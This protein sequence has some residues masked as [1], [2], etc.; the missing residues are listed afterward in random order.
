[1]TEYKCEP[2][3]TIIKHL[4]RIGKLMLDGDDSAD[5]SSSLI[6]NTGDDNAKRHE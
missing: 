2:V 5:Q 4:R 1:V 3:A 6:E